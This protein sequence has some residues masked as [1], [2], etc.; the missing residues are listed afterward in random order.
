MYLLSGLLFTHI[1]CLSRLNDFLLDT[2]AM[3][4]VHASD[5]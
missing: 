4:F 2:F 1:D 5:L 3:S